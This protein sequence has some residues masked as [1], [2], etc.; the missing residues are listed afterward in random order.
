MTQ[1]AAEPRGF[2]HV[3]RRAV[4]VTCWYIVRGLRLLGQHFTAFVWTTETG[5]AER[6]HGPRRL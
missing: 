3:C 1:P 5:D 4:P 2:G 6:G